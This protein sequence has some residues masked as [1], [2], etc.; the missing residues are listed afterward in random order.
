MFGIS[1]LALLNRLPAVIVAP[2]AVAA[3]LYAGHLWNVVY[4]DPHVRAA[5]RTEYVNEVTAK[6]DEEM[7]WEMQRQKD[8]GAAAVEQL[9]KTLAAQQADH[10]AAVQ[11]LEQ[12]I[13]DYEKAGAR[14]PLTQPD[15]DWLHQ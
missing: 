8:A 9:N 14:C 12:E 5:A 7:R 11:K 6:A 10:D 2:V 4:H 3:S 15:L 13:A 1:L